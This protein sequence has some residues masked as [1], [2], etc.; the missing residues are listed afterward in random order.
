[1]ESPSSQISKL[2][3]ENQSLLSSLST[4]QTQTQHQQQQLSEYK[5]QIDTLTLT[6]QTL[7]S[8]NNDIPSLIQSKTKSI[9][10]LKSQ[11]K[12]KD[13]E[14]RAL[15]IK[16]SQLQSEHKSK[17]TEHKHKLS[18][19]LNALT[20]ANTENK[21]L[22]T[23]L[24]EVKQAN[25]NQ[26]NEIQRLKN[27]ITTL[28]TTV[29][30]LRKENSELKT[31]NTNINESLSLLNHEHNTLNKE[32]NTQLE[33]KGELNN[34]LHKIENDLQNELSHIKE[35]NQQLINKN[36]MLNCKVDAIEC[37]Y[38][39]VM[40]ENIL[41]N[42]A[43]INAD[44][45]EKKL[46]RE[47]NTTINELNIEI[48]KM[49]N[50]NIKGKEANSKLCNEIETLSK[51]YKRKEIELY[52]LHMEYK[53]I[54]THVYQCIELIYTFINNYITLIPKH[55]QHAYCQVVNDFVNNIPSS[56]NE[57][58]KTFDSKQ[59]V[60]LIHSFINAVNNEADVLYQMLVLH[61]NNNSKY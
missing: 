45:N 46:K 35:Q 30:A 38:K 20:A 6:I 10:S 41:K 8:S 61:T 33:L 24:T 27:E 14:I 11:L 59:Q 7:T 23:T 32:Y 57:I 15:N 9:I 55:V 29:N 40:N 51:E 53:D 18:T 28:Q 4:L 50:D 12:D 37:K 48:M 56:L 42:E 3:C 16:L 2:L 34:E 49:R 1:M 26:H 43:I 22:H 44:E 60:Q 39:K 17:Q 13:R 47:L 31:L 36:I 52:T 19:T 5:S 21:Q 58:E 25:T 54:V